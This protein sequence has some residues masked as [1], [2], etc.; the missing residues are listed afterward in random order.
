MSAPGPVPSPLSRA[1]RFQ[2]AMLSLLPGAGSVVVAGQLGPLSALP[3]WTGTVLGAVVGTVVSAGVYR[4]VVGV[5]NRAGVV[6]QKLLTGGQSTPYVAT[7]SD[8]EALTWRGV[9]HEAAAAWEAAVAQSPTK[10]DLLLK[11]AEFFAGDGAEPHRALTLFGAARTAAGPKDRGTDHYATNRIIDLLTGPLGDIPRG[12]VEL[13]ALAQR[14]P[15]S[16]TARY[17]PQAL[18]ELASRAAA[19]PAAAPQS[20]AAAPAATRTPPAAARDAG[21]RMQR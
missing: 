15:T 9:R 5:I 13:R 10:V 18:A 17:A 7:H 6:T 19:A 8:L 16:A 2:I 4:G 12:M 14:Q 21:R 1:Q 3:G 11:A 20:A